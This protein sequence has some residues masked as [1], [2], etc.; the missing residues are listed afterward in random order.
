MAS[1]RD[2]LRIVKLNTDENM[3]TPVN[4][5][6]KGIPTIILFRDGARRPAPRARSRASASRRSS[7]RRW[8]RPGARRCGASGP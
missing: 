2:D 8:P 7:S 6:I 5:G 3:E 1:E 4:F